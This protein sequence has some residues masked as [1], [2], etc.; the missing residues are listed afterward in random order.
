M[1]KYIVLFA[2]LALI[3]G[4]CSTGTDNTKEKPTAKGDRIYGGCLRL[5]MIEPFQ[6]LYP[7]EVTDAASLLIFT[8]TNDGL[9]KLNTA[10]LKA[11]PCLAESWNIDS[12]GTKYT[13]HL[14]KG[15][16]F[17]DDECYQGGIGREIKASDVKYSFD[18]L[19]TKNIHNQNF[20]STFK[21]R[22]LGANKFYKEGKGALEGVKVIDEYTLEI[23]LLRP[24]TVFLSILAEP[25]C[26]VVSKEAIE[27]YGKNVKTGGTGAFIFD[28]NKSSKDRTVLKRNP[29]YHGKDKFGNQLPFLDSIIATVVSSKEQELT[30]FKEG[31][32]D[33]IAT[34][35]SQSVKEMVESQIKD[36]QSKPPK[37]MLDNSPEMITQYYTFNTK[38]PPFNNVKVRK[39]FN[40]AIN[41]Q[42]IIDE[43]LNGQAYG[44]GIKGITPPTFTAD[45][46]DITGIK[47]YD[48]N[49]QE[50]KKL[51]AAAG[52]P[53]GKGFP[54]IKILLN[55]GS[56]RNSN[57]VV[58]IQKQL[59]EIL[60]I[61]ID[62]DVIP[63]AQKLE[64]SKTGRAPLVRDAWIADFP[65]P[66][67]FLDLFYGVNV[68]AEPNQLSFPN[69]SRYQNPEFDKYFEM[70]RDAQLKDSAM[71]YFMKAEQIMMDD[72]PIMVLWYEGNYRLT[73][74]RVKNA[75]SNAMHYRNFSETYIKEGA[76]AADAMAGESKN[77][78]IK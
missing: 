42:K 28:V 56:S 59:K 3:F 72:A 13:F 19:C 77:D 68:P 8:Q 22:V 36:F 46:Y 76:T 43:V 39:A 12:S 78:S 20:L 35:P 75:P 34:L 10:T 14:Q 65:S 5:S 9:V 37:F 1:K 71:F 24:S 32:I 29:K 60:G 44:S 64:E 31:K 25:A 38:L 57:V 49:P 51:L 21:D 18:L 33:M 23:T 74:F 61:N 7:L 4:A 27:R 41:R 11:E 54:N 66:E 70:G 53:N 63:F 67:S 45:G 47:G 50:A 2:A 48:Y 62:F 55:G 40:M 6:T 69:T 30:L 26:A 17:Q 15:A 52:Y 58:E 16:M 73:Q